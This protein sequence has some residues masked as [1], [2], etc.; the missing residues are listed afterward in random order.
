ML[1]VGAELVGEVEV[2]KEL[3]GE[4]EKELVGEAGVD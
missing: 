3:V 4:V 1:E 2:E